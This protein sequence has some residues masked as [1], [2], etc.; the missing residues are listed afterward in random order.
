MLCESKKKERK[1]QMRKIDPV[2]DTLLCVR[3]SSFS[4]I[5]IIVQHDRLKITIVTH[6]QSIEIMIVIFDS[7]LVQVLL[8]VQDGSIILPGVTRCVLIVFQITLKNLV[9]VLL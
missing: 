3:R 7:V 6:F 4:Q 9:D 1:C 5:I 2:V 8:H